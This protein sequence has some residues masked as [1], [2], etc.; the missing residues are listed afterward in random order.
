MS[1]VRGHRPA[2]QGDWSVGLFRF[3]S[4]LLFNGADVRETTKKVLIQLVQ[5]PSPEHVGLDRTRSRGLGSAVWVD[6][7][8]QSKDEE[9]DDDDQQDQQQHS[10]RTPLAAI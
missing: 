5:S 2:T 3:T 8:L 7:T 6:V 10:N 9:E 1:E 4:Q